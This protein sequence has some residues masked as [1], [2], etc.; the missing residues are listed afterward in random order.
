MQAHGAEQDGGR[1]A[2]GNG[3]AQQ[4]DEGAAD[5]GVV[6]RFSRDNAVIG[7]GAEKFRGLAALAGGVVA[8][9]R[10]DVLADAGNGADADADGA[11]FQDRRVRRSIQVEIFT[12]RTEFM[13][14][15]SDSAE[16]RASSPSMLGTPNRPIMAGT[17][18]MPLS[19][20][21]LPNE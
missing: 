9:P 6:C 1:R 13:R 12:W 2:A 21:T 8:E 10:R 16:S 20:C 14:M 11:G 4:G 3:K 15:A 17:K 18:A 19:S 5:A 7:A